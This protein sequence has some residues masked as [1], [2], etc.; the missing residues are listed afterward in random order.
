MG[1]TV[2][3]E[4]EFVL[5]TSIKSLENLMTTPSGLSEWYADNVDIK[6]DIYTFVWD[7][8]KE[9]ARLLSLKK[10]ASI[11]WRWLH[12]EEESNKNDYYFEF[13]YAI[14]SMTNDVILKVTDVNPDG[15]DAEEIEHLWEDAIEDLRGVLGA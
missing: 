8:T 14:D 7:E 13:S 12:H 2:K 9:D 3:I 1:K 11:R 6:N 15:A 5:R 4:L 10:G